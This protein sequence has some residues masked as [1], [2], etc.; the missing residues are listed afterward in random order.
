MSANQ[1]A[2]PEP[3]IAA[4]LGTGE[5]FLRSTEAIHLTGRVKLVADEKAG[6]GKVLEMNGDKPATGNAP[7]EN[8]SGAEVYAAHTDRGRKTTGT[9]EFTLKLQPNNFGV[10]LRRKLDYAFPNQ[11]AEVF[12]ADG[13]TEPGEGDWEPAGIWYLAGAN[14]CVYSNPKDELGA[15]QHIVQTSNRRF[16]DDEFLVARSLTEGRSA[17]RVRVKFTPVNT[18]LFPG[19][20]LAELAW[21]EIRYDAYCFVMPQWKP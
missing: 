1:S 16:R 18:P 15:T 3:T 11:R 19:H 10:L 8:R 21:S 17:I 2:L 4:R 9:S 12:I 6:S 13:T 7:A 20:P 5:I 14:T